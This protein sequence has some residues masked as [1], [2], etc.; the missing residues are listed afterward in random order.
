VAIRNWGRNLLSR[1][2]RSNLRRLGDWL[3]AKPRWVITLAVALFSLGPIPTNDIFIAAGL[4]A[5]PLAPVVIGFLIGSSI[6]FTAYD[7]LTKSVASNLKELFLGQLTNPGG[8]I[9]G[10]F[11]LVTPVIVLAKMNWEKILHLPPAQPHPSTVHSH[12]P[13]DSSPPER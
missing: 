5:I 1:D 7:L 8:L 11:L 2:R 10:V 4:T 9:L 3:E 13:N 12:D 6:S